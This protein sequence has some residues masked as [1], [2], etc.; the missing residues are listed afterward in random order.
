MTKEQ[1]QQN[2]LVVRGHVKREERL[3]LLTRTDRLI[4]TNVLVHA[5]VFLD[6]SK[7]AVAR[8]VVLP[9][10]QKGGGLT[11]LQ[12]LCEF[13][14]VVT[15]KIK[16]PMPVNK[17][18]TI[19]REILFSPRWHVLDRRKETLLQAVELVKRHRMPF[20]DALIAACML[21][22]EVHT[23]VTENAPDFMKV[24]GIKVVNPF[25]AR[26]MR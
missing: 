9:I 16:Q 4:D 21:E 11:T 23:I 20:W 5:Y 25:K 2:I 26:V 14:I 1:K 13:F 24:P 6:T 3:R 19:V 8:G 22:H 12:N 7:Q 10:W 18:G 15:R 17:A